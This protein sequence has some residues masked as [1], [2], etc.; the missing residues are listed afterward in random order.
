MASTYTIKKGDTL[1]TVARQLGVDSAQLA[2]ANN[3][4]AGTNLTEGNV[5]NVP[6][7]TNGNAASAATGNAPA[8]AQP[9]KNLYGLYESTQQKL[10]E[11][12]QGYR[13]SE[14]VNAAQQYLQSVINGKPG[15]YQSQ[16]QG[17]LE[18]L[19]NQV[20]NRDPFT[21]DLN[22]DMLYNQYKDQYTQLGQQAMMD[23]M[24]QAAAMTGGYGNSYAQTAG[25]Q[26]Y[27][28][29]LTQLNNIV[30]DLYQM[31]YDR[32]NQAGADLQSKLALTQSLEDAAYGRYRDTVSDWNTERGYASDEYWNQYNAD[33]TDYANQLQHWNNLAQM[34]HSQYFNRREL[35]YAQAMAILQTGNVPDAS[36]LKTA[37]ISAA[38]AK[39]LAKAYK[40]G[41]SG[42][43]GG[44]GRS[45][46]SSSRSYSSYSGS[47]NSSSKD[48]SGGGITSYNQLSSNAKAVF[49]STGAGSGYAQNA[50]TRAAIENTLQTELNRGKIT[51]S[52]ATY[53]AEK[54]GY[55]IE[56][57]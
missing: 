19:Y 30:P 1:D 44:S 51:K 3:L 18:S 49:A 7:A 13:P 28:Q 2:T 52:E 8:A 32:Y 57:E 53:I 29:Y 50:N 39:N 55:K 12:G 15:D 54:R 56:F 33:Y 10:G 38:D 11:L 43:S 6:A 5:L 22:G 46:G 17:Q 25:Q 35:A 14:S 4:Q 31:A 41:G 47:N 48:S 37:G 45:G 21:F 36:L 24:G 26:A 42:G 34:E 20:M 9:Y 27:Q 23:T 40:K 16:Y